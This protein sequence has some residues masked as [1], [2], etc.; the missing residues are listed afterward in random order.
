VLREIRDDLVEI[1]GDA[2]EFGV[3]R[4]MDLDKLR[5]MS[6]DRG[7]CR[8]HVCM[9][10]RDNEVDQLRSRPSGRVV[11]RVNGGWQRLQGMNHRLRIDGRRLARVNDRSATS[12]T[13][14]DAE[15]FKHRSRSEIG[16]D[17]LSNGS[18]GELLV[19]VPLRSAQRSDSA[20]ATV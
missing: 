18:Q 8:S 6:R 14:V 17:D 9:M 5:E 13:E 15:F 2:R 19:H 12:T 20:D 11:A 7:H 16:D 3:P 10:R 1:C 4:A